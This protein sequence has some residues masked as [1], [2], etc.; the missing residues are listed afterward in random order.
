MNK[1]RIGDTITGKDGRSY[2]VQQRSETDVMAFDKERPR[3][4]KM[5]QIQEL[6][7]IDYDEGLWQQVEPIRRSA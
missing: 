4:G 6:H 1:P 2:E 7:C 5:F 3:K